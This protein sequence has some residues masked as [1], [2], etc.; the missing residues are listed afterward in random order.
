MWPLAGCQSCLEPWWM[1][2][3]DVVQHITV[4][5]HLWPLH[6][7]ITMPCSVLHKLFSETRRQNTI[8]P[9]GLQH[10]GKGYGWC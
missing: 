5:K 7:G 4:P 10:L 6:Q 8:L 2:V 9:L 3:L 1:A